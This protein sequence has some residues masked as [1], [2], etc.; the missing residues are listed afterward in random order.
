MAGLLLTLRHGF[1]VGQD[2]LGFDRLD[3]ARRIDRPVDM[4]DVVVLKA[5]HDVD[6][7][8][9]L[10]DVGEELV[11]QTLAA[12][13][14]LDQTGDVDELDRRGGVL[15]GMVHFAQHVQTAVRHGHHAGVRLDGTERI[16][17]GLRA[18]AGDGVKQRALADVRQTDDS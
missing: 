2:Q 1:H 3:V 16:I 5:A 11:A 6:D 13:R 14:A 10:A 12:A 18:G 4:D 17:G 9:H 7:R 8:V 15:L